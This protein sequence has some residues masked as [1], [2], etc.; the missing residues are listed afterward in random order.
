MGVIKL[1]VVI[2]SKNTLSDYLKDS[3]DKHRSYKL[4]TSMERA[5]GFLVSGRFF[6]TNGETW[7]DT[8]DREQV[9][10][11]TYIQH[12]FLGR[13]EKMLQCGC[14]MEERM[15]LCLIFILR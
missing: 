1:R 3:A 12:Y 14:Y 4:Y 6:L 5:L 8:F 11:K 10:E 7:N 15:E 2:D 13:Q 9:K